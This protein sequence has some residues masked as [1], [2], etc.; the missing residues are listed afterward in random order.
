MGGLDSTPLFAKLVLGYGQNRIRKG[1]EGGKGIVMSLK[2]LTTH[3]PL[4][5]K[6]GDPTAWNHTN[7][8]FL[9]YIIK[10]LGQTMHPGIL[11]QVV[12]KTIK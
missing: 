4:I 11:S 7:H 3:S 12:S 1:F 9:A 6:A 8:C 10:S 2:V 5:L